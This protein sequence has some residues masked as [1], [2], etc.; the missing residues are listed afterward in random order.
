M[1]FYLINNLTTQF[2][3]ADY[4]GLNIQK[5]IAGS[6]VYAH[7]FSRCVIATNEDDFIGH[8]D[9]TE[10]TQEQYVAEKQAILEAY[11]KTRETIEETITAQQTQID[12]LIIMLGD[13]ILNGGV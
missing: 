2:G 13:T 9:V 1:K 11:P 8:P 6:Q 10:L 3:E 4:K 5:F 12:E 7:D